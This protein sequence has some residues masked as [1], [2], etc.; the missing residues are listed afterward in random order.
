MTTL[1]EVIK[2][3]KKKVA[4]GMPEGWVCIVTEQK[5]SE[6]SKKISYGFSFEKAENAA[7]GKTEIL[8]GFIYKTLQIIK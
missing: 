6:R 7:V 8:D 3:A 1:N 4:G 2:D 5:P